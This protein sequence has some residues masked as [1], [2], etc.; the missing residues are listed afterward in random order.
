VRSDPPTFA[1]FVNNPTLMHFSYLRY[2]ENRI[3]AEYNFLGTPIKLAA[4]GRK[5]K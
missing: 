2:L 1:L 5:E 3:R 4:K